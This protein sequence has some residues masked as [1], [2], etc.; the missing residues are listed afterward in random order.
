[1]GIQST[2]S[3]K[4]LLFKKP[5]S[6]ELLTANNVDQSTNTT[7]TKGTLPL[8]DESGNILGYVPIYANANLA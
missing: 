1:M 5:V 3:A 2:A 7:L 8:Y 4:Q 6:K